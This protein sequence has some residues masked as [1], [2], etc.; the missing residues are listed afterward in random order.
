MCAVRSSLN[1]SVLHVV[2][3]LPAL[4]TTKNYPLTASFTSNLYMIRLLC[5]DPTWKGQGAIV[6][7]LRPR[8]KNADK[9]EQ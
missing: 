1:V 3:R 6:V 9:N 5:A 7:V 8:G 2:S 4:I